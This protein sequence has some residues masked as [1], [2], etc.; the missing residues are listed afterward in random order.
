MP[1]A[2]YTGWNPRHPS[3][4]G[5][6]QI[7]EGPGATLPFAATA[8]ER[9][10]TGDPRPSIAE[11]YRDRAGYLSLICEAAE[12]LVAWRHLLAE[13]IPLVLELAGERYDSFAA[14]PVTGSATPGQ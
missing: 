12:E 9:E 10:R 7:V 8:E 4:G 14:A 2:T 13:D 3:T 6:G 11:R 5:D 1:L